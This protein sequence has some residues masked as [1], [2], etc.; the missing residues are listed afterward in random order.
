MAS[1]DYSLPNRKRL[2]HGVMY[3]DSQPTI[4]FDT[5]STK[6]RR[7]WLGSPAV[8]ALLRKVWSEASLWLVGRYVI[9]NLCIAGSGITGILASAAATNMKKIGRTFETIRCVPG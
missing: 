9:R 7:P 1:P 6:H 2:R 4:V 5:I 3:F 8:H